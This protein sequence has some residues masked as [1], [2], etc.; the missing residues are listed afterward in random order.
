MVVLG[1]IDALFGDAA[2]WFSAPAL[3]GTGYLV[4]SLLMGQ[5][6][7][8]V[9]LDMDGDVDLTIDDGG[10]DGSHDFKVLSLQ[11]IAAFSMGAGWMGL[12]SYR[13]LGLN[14]GAS[15]L[16]AMVSGIAVASLMINSLRMLMKLQSSGNI[17]LGRAIG[18][19]GTVYVEVPPK[20]GGRGRVTVVL[21]N[22]QREFNAVQVGESAIASRT[23]IA[24]V[25]IDTATN[26]VTVEAV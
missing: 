17:A 8:D 19:T 11:S 2:V 23:R 26:T 3:F 18:A 9:D 6:G 10:H 22:R 25:G 1:V 15:A 5:L 16:I 12:V 4:I 21:D 13:G 14:E 24:V 20:D 7:G